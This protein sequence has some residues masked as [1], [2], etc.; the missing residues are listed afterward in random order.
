MPKIN[1]LPQIDEI[2]GLQKPALD[3]RVLTALIIRRELERLEF[4]PADL[5]PGAAESALHEMRHASRPANP[6]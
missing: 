3:L 2:D 4:L 6:T 1:L 5:A